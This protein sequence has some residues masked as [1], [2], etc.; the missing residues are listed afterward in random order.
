MEEGTVIMSGLDSDR[1]LQ[2]IEYSILNK[3]YS[4]NIIRDYS[5]KNVSD[6]VLKVIISYIDYV[7]MRRGQ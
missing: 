3:D 1:V 4:F 6:T 5:F 7:N 2:S